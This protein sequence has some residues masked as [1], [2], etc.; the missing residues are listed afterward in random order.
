MVSSLYETDEY[1]RTFL[2]L[3]WLKENYTPP[4]HTH[5]LRVQCLNKTLVSE[6]YLNKIKF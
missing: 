5:T 2:D 1:A 6:N 3:K 4:P